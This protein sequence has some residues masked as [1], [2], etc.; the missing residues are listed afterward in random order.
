MSYAYRCMKCRTRNT[1]RQPLER[2]IRIPRC[3]R[4]L[5]TT[6]YVDKERQ[7][8]TDIC[9]CDGYHFKH[10]IKSTFCIHNPLYQFNVRTMRFGEDPDEVREDIAFH[11]AITC[12][13]EEAPF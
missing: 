6:F 12:T 9:T 5:N 13:T 3:K 10:R 2:Y 1:L 11:E 7:F 8:R 4:C